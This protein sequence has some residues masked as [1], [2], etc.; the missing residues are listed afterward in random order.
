MNIKAYNSSYPGSMSEKADGRYIFREDA[1][2][3]AGALVEQIATLKRQREDLMEMVKELQRSGADLGECVSVIEGFE[4][5]Y[6]DWIDRYGTARQL[7][8]HMEH[9]MR[10]EDPRY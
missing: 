8:T 5:E 2:S 6:E 7:I 3:L 9:Q 10:Y 1:A 4:R